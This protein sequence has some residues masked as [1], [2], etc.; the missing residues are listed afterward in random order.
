VA[1]V[2]DPVY[3]EYKGTTISSH[4]LHFNIKNLQSTTQK[5]IVS[6]YG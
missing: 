1:S 5:F 3:I 2:D 6:Q 4:H